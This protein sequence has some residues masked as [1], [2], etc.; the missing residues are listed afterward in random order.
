MFCL[1]WQFLPEAFI[2]STEGI[3]PIPVTDRGGL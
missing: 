3:K 2:H 1:R